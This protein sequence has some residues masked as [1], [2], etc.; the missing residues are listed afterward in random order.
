M[1]QTQTRKQQAITI[2][3]RVIGTKAVQE[4]PKLA[5]PKVIEQLV[6]K[7]GMTNGGASTYYANLK[8]GNWS[9]T[10]TGAKATTAPVKA[11]KAA[12]AGTTKPAAKKA[13]PAKAKKAAA[14]ATPSES[15]EDLQKMAAD[16]GISETF[17]DPA[18]AKAAIEAATAAK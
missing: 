1:A 2:Y 17:T 16:L 8:N 7:L 10:V 13:T 14:P 11:V 6:S 4:N 9:V 5:R 15:L 12:K 3:K 18:A